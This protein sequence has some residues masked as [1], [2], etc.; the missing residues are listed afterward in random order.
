[1][2]GVNANARNQVFEFD[3]LGEAH[4]YRGALLREFGPFLGKRIIEIGAG[5]GQFTELLAQQPGVMQVLA[6]E[7]EARFCATFRQRCPA[8]TVIEGTLQSAALEPA[9]DNIVSVNVLEHIEQ[10]V[11]ELKDY[12]RVLGP[13]RGRLCLFVPARPEIYAPID[14]DFGHFRRYRR[15]ELMQKLEAAGFRVLRAHYFNLVGYFGWW[16][17]FCLLKQRQFNPAAVRLFDRRIFPITCLLE[18]RLL[19][20]PWGQSLVVIAE[21]G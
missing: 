3:A 1:M 10:D 2:S 7:P 8:L 19:R 18:Q 6:I 12:G 16:L 20:P 9:W 4:N 14:K 5:I 13:T 17:T 21:A 15:P 11:A